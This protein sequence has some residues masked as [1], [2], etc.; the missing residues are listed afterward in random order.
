MI[1][2]TLGKA[3]GCAGAFAACS[4]TMASYIRNCAR[5]FVFSTA[6]PP[7][8][9]ACAVA[10]VPLVAEA[11][12]RR[13]ALSRHAE[14]LRLRVRELGHQAVGD[15]HIV[16]VIIGDAANTMRISEH[17][18]S[19]GVFAQGIR[20]PTVPSGSSRIRLAPI[21]THTDADIDQVVDAFATIEGAQLS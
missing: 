20:P 19:H 8:V 12:G 13:S 17:L 4:E 1:V 14:T 18:L 9:A 11:D 5:S 6:P 7:F 21:A 10:A 2:G 16:P 3:F 15:A